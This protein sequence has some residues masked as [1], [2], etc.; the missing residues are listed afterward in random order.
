MKKLYLVLTAVFFLSLGARAQLVITGEIRPRA[1]F[2]NGFK[3]L[4][5]SDSHPAFFIE[6]R[7]RLYVDF[8]RERI[9]MRISVQDVRL[10]GENNQIFK[11]D[12]AFFGVHEA[13]GQYHFNEKFK[14]RVGRQELDY[15]N[16]RILGDLS[17]AQQSR[18][19]DALKITYEAGKFKWHLGAAYNQ[20]DVLSKPEPARLSDTFYSGVSNYKTMQYTWLNRSGEKVAWSLMFLNNGLQAADSSVHF[21]Q[22]LGGNAETKVKGI[23]CTAEAWYQ[24]G[25]DGQGADLSAYLLSL[26]IG[27]K[28]GGI[29]V[30]LGADH[31]SGTEA[32]STKNTSFD[33][34]YGTHHKFYGFMDYFYV[35]N[36]H[37]NVGLTDL[38][39][40]SKFKLGEKSAL[41]IHLHEFFSGARIVTEQAE[42]MSKN[43]GTEIDLVYAVTIAPDV[44][45]N[46]GYSQLFA[47]SS[48][49]QIKGG[50]KSEVQNWA[51]AMLTIKPKIFEK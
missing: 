2:R 3:R 37:G 10:W 11:S 42:K 47:S 1:E 43:L 21:S 40:R 29:P 19:H 13:W 20:E 50:E 8:T 45:L 31:L 44:S 12:N 7:S 35:G 18:T 24:L 5:A 6:Q 26:N 39:V 4:H 22:T 41:N 25:K 28:A 23:T 30:I 14:L 9:T 48:M 34:L 36:P 49:E 17:W 27:F 51:W 46:L 32:S 16:A 38:Y 15:D 33:P